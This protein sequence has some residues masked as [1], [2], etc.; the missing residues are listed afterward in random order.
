MLWLANCVSRVTPP[1]AGFALRRRLY[2]LGGVRI[3]DGA[4]ICGGVAITNRFVTIG[5]DS[6]VGHGTRIIG[7][8]H[9]PISVGANC[10]LGPEVL[11]VCGS[12]AIGGTHRRAGDGVS[13]LISIG[14]GTWLGARATVLGGVVIGKGCVVAAGSVVTDSVEP[15]SLVGGVPGRLLRTL[16]H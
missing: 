16:S 9:A 8:P 11:L 6:W 10:D 13:R 3:A 2:R 1:T 12:H 14:D 15:N 7:G 4:R 5:S